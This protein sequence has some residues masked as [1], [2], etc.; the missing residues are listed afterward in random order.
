MAATRDTPIESQHRSSLLN[1]VLN[2]TEALKRKE[3]IHRLVYIGKLRFDQSDKR[4]IGDYY[5]KFYKNH[6]SHAQVEPV[7]GLLLI[8]PQNFVHV[9]EAST[10]V[11]METIKDLDAKQKRG[12]LLK[13]AKVLLS[14]GNIPVRLYSQWNYRVLNLPAIRT[15]ETKLAESTE[16]LLSEA[17]A[18]TLK[19]GYQ[20]SRVSKL[21]LKTSLDQMHDKY[22][23]L[24][25]PEDIIEKILK[26]QDLCDPSQY[27]KK[28]CT[29]L[30]ITLD[31]DLVWP[32]ETKLFPL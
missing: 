29:P 2:R 9:I 20:L 31:R 11:L 12:S 25:I 18:L 5:E 7:T 3:L 26:S 19:L 13:E 30:E 14:V 1:V 4:E 15:D 8:Y 27:L 32:A 22:R 16:N 6:N 28:Y 23:D 17:L 21:S 24:L 10:G